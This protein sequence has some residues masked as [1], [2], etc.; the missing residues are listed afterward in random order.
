MNETETKNIKKE[1]EIKKEKIHSK[2][3]LKIKLEKCDTVPKSEKLA[4][5]ETVTKSENI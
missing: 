1:H 4:K 2:R 5:C 3:E